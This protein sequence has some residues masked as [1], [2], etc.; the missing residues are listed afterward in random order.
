MEVTEKIYEKAKES[1]VDKALIGYEVDGK[2]MVDDEVTKCTCG[3]KNCQHLVAV[4]I[5][6]GME[7]SVA[8]EGFPV[9][10]VGGYDRYE[11]VSAFHKEMRRGDKKEAYYWLDVMIQSGFSAWYVNNYI[12]SILGEELCHCDMKP[13]QEIKTLANFKVI[14]EYNLYAMVEKFCEAKKWWFCEKCSQRRKDWV[15]THK[16]V[17]KG[18][19]KVPLYALDTHTRRGKKLYANGE[20]DMRWSGTDK[21]MAWRE[22]V[23]KAGIDL[24]EAE[25]DDVD[26][27][28]EK[29]SDDIE[30][31]W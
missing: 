28:D 31:D 25:W 1:R 22:R 13:F 18:R 29:E 5:K 30:K 23:V 20:A 6:N 14:D 27:S 26:M 11:V 7:V 15:E 9:E 16:A 17:K 4:A 12:V 21:G 3:V 10:C 19:K 24:L 2:Y 8:K